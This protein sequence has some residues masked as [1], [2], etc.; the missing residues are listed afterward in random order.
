[1]N[2]AKHLV[3]LGT[4]VV[5][6]GLAT[7]AH[8]QTSGGRISGAVT[9]PTGAAVPNA[10]I[11]VKN[12]DTQVKRDVTANADGLYS[13][14]NLVPG[15]YEVR[16]SATGFK[17]VVRPELQVE[18]G[19]E[20]VINVELS[21][22]EVTEQV[23]VTADPPIVELATSAISNVVNEK[24]VVELPL[25][26]RDWTT[27]A[28][29]QPGVATVRT[30]P[31]VAISNQR[32]NRGLGAQLTIEG[33]RPQQNNYRLDGISI[34]DYSNGAPGS[35]LGVDLGVEAIREFSV[36]TSNASAEYGKSSGG[37]INAAS[38]SGSNNFHG[39]AYEFHRN[40]ALDARNFFDGAKIP[41]FKRNQFGVAAGGPI[42]RDRTFIFG[43]Y[44]GLRQNLAVNFVSSVPSDA[45]R[46]GQLTA[47]AVTVDPL[48]IPYLA[49][50][51][52]TNGSVNADTGLFSFA[53]QQV[54]KENYFTLRADHKISNR[55]SIFGTYMFDNG[56]SRSPD[57]FNNKNIATLSQRRL[58]TVEENHVFT[59]NFVNAARFG[60]SRV[61]SLAPVTLDAI[62]PAASDTALGFV[63][64][65]AA[66]LINITGIANFQG[67]LGAVG[68]FDFHFNDIQF[69]DDVFYT[70]GSHS[71][72]FGAVVER[73][74]ANQLGKANP[75]GQYIFGS[76]ANFLTNK[77]TSF[78]APLSIGVSPR[79]LRQTIFGGYFQDDWKLRPNLTLNLGLRYEFASVPTEVNN[80]LSVLA[81]ITDA[82]P[83]LGSPYFNN[84]TKR[85]FAPRVGFAWD[86]FRN[87]KTSVRGAFGIYDV[88]P[89]TYQFELLS[90]FAAPFQQLG[91][92]SFTAANQQGAFPKAAFPLLNPFNLRNSF[93]EQNPKRNYTMQWN[94]NVQREIAP[95][96]T[97][98][99]GYVGS[100]GVHQPTRVDDANMVQPTLTSQGYVY[101]LPIGSGTRLNPNVGQ[102]SALFYEGSSIYHAMH[103]QVTKRLSHGFQ[104]QGSYTWSKSIDTG[105]SSVAGDTFGNSVSSLPL[106]NLRLVRGLSDFDIRHNLVV[107]YLWQIPTRQSLS[108]PLG[109]IAKG[110]QLGGILQSSSGLPFTATIGGDSLGL[111]SADTF[112]FP[113]RVSSSDCANPVNPGNPTHYIKTECL[114]APPL[115]TLGNGGRN[116]LTGPR[117][118]DFDMSLIKNTPVKWISETFN[119]QLRMEVFNIFNHTN[120][121][122]PT[123]PNRQIFNGALA[124]NSSAG[125]LTGT[126]N[127]SRQIQ[128]ALKL[129]W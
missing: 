37:I 73:L 121:A 83:K 74:Q 55:D 10:Q 126:A 104:F 93:I 81:N 9:D 43:D 4:L 8:A 101:P 107:S 35:V 116:T 31:T 34:N 38:R 12:T 2:P 114:T 89:L 3:N 127:T 124:R 24:T 97:V 71:F 53:G 98:L 58:Y 17:T 105:S 75:N 82:A 111:R 112:G 54:T 1:M 69:Y 115:G 67:G 49:L 50:Y 68:E 85:N 109:V 52:R 76:L 14:P 62:N 88:L 64:G 32:A 123:N 78:N 20:L 40:S 129:N 95:N 59:S 47:G 79:D 39:S 18:V 77:P 72:K 122:P 91:N 90:I 60:F 42:W 96:L 87:G 99:L 36:V 45:A 84:P 26:G 28:T 29:L 125:T 117:L 19:S 23:L 13:V 16:V 100:H 56:T 46:A 119:V 94:L 21:V 106:F 86:P 108:G 30:Q 11:A 110:W 41:P 70:K 113:N 27:L 22:G 65:L 44:E 6:F 7:L 80:K 92:I 51:P 61:V 33:N 5:L 66:G 120:F 118:N 15:S 102:I 128:V 25:N 48:V 63:P 57:T 103:L